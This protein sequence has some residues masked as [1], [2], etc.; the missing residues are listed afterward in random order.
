LVELHRRAKS[1]PDGRD[2]ARTGSE[3]HLIGLTE[4]D[5]TLALL[6]EPPTGQGWNFAEL[7]DLLDAANLREAAVLIGLI[8]RA[9]AWQVLLTRR[10]EQMSSHA[11]QVAFP[12]GRVDAGDTSAIATAI[13]ETWEEVGVAAEHIR[14]IGFLERFATISNYIVTPVVAILSADIAPKP[15][16]SEVAAIFEAPLDLFLDPNA[17]RL[18][19]RE[20]R[21]RVRSTHVF[22]FG[23]HRIWGA[24]ASMLL[25]FVGR[26]EQLGIVESTF[27]EYD[28]KHLR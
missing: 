24:T 25:N 26:I 20:F 12:G 3:S 23:E 13:R 15:Q 7:A 14:P 28:S 18:E 8:K 4:Q 6:P 27:E 11:G 2:F 9:G 1:K 5:L 22:Q 19:T 10:T 21:G 16:Q 17:R